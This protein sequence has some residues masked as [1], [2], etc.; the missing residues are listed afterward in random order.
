M[1]VSEFY[2]IID[3]FGVRHAFK[4]HGH[5]QTEEPRGQHAILPE[6]F[7]LILET[8]YFFDKISN[9][10]SKKGLLVIRYEKEFED[11]ILVYAEEIRF[12]QR[13]L[14]FQTLYKRKIR[15]P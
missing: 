10:Y 3:N 7:D 15:K 9:E 6:D 1:D 12:G 5:A 14:A 4:K 11:F 13:E 2:R 8:V